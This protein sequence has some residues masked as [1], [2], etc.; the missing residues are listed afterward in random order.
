MGLQIGNSKVKEVKIGE[1][2]TS[3]DYTFTNQPDFTVTS[4]DDYD[5]V[6]L[7]NSIDSNSRIKGTLTFSVSKTYTVQIQKSD[8]TYRTTSVTGTTIDFD[9]YCVNG[10]LS[11]VSI[12][13]QDSNGLI[14]IACGITFGNQRILKMGLTHNRDYIDYPREVTVTLTNF[15]YGTISTAPTL[16]YHNIKEIYVGSNKVFPVKQTGWVTAWEGN[17]TYTTTKTGG[18]YNQKIVP[19]LFDNVSKETKLRMTGTFKIT[20]GYWK[21]I[22]ATYNYGNYIYYGNDPT[23]ITNPNSNV[24]DLSNIEFYVNKYAPGAGS[25]YNLLT[26]QTSKK[27]SFGMKGYFEYSYNDLAFKYETTEDNYAIP[28]TFNITKIE[29]Y[30]PE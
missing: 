5:D 27:A 23:Y 24:I 30:I 26:I 21:L 9:A 14:A 7:I 18:S 19:N 20:S 4:P 25:N 1:I 3:T 17:F 22:S 16:S 13:W 11:A 15:Q 6:V 10:N 8:G 29:A 28:V 2:G 12:Y